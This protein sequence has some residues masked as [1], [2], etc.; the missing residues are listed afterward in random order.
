MMPIVTNAAPPARIP[1]VAPL[2][3]IPTAVL[4]NPVLAA[5]PSAAVPVAVIP[6]AIPFKLLINPLPSETV[7]SIPL[8][9]PIPLAIVPRPLANPPMILAP[10]PKNFK[11]G[12]IAAAIAPHLMMLCCC[13][14]DISLNFLAM[15]DSVCSHGFA[16]SKP[17]FNAFKSGPP[18]SIAMSVSLFLKILSCDSVVS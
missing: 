18:N 10:L 7:L 11:A 15:S 6:V 4:H 3:N 17:L 8:N 2:P 13:S 16:A 12:P 14:V 9:L 5:A 1:Q